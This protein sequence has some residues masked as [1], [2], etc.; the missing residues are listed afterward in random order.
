MCVLFSQGGTPE[1]EESLSRVTESKRVEKSS[2]D[3]VLSPSLGEVLSD[4]LGRMDCRQ[5][6]AE[7]MGRMSCVL[8]E[9]SYAIL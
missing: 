7:L 4:V 5:T 8:A 2:G 3:D 1:R 9:A 6:L